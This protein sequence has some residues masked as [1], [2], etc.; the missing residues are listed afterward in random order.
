MLN[1][2]GGSGND[3]KTAAALRA[4][5]GWTGKTTPWRPRRAI[6]PAS[7]TTNK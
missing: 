7:F 5:R 3:A 2:K 6:T 4:N 1:K